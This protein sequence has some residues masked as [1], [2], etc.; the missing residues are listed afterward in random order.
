ML[1]QAV[2]FVATQ[3]H[4]ALSVIEIESTYGAGSSFLRERKLALQY[5]L[6]LSAGAL[7]C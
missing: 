5:I 3:V 2:L 6:D 1:V 7:Y 4:A